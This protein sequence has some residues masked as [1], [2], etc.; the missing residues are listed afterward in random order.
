MSEKSNNLVS[1]SDKY[2]RTFSEEFKRQKVA[3]IIAKRIKV[4]E[5]CSLYNVSRTSVHK[6]IYLYSSNERGTKTVVQME[7]EAEKT[8]A[9]QAQLAACE[10]AL[11]QKQM[12]IDL[13]ETYLAKISE[14]VGYDVKKTYG[15]KR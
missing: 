12:E 4:S 3:D 15:R 13:L 6:W 1:N 14:E 2:N 7:S 9:L 10:R 5:L 11:G 8:K